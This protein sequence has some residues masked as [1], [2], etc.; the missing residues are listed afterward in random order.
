MGRGLRYGDEYCMGN[1]RFQELEDRRML[2]G[3]RGGQIVQAFRGRMFIRYSYRDTFYPYPV[4]KLLII[5]L[6]VPMHR[7][8][9]MLTES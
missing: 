3:L 7:L 6:F 5:H 8:L 9:E 1:S 4:L 2:P